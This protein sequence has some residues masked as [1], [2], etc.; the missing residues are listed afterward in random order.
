MF[1]ANIAIGDFFGFDNNYWTL[2]TKAQ[3]IGL[4]DLK[5]I[6]QFILFD[7][8]LESRIK[9]LPAVL[10]AGLTFCANQ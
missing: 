6:L 8:L 9:F 4:F 3:A 1:N 5:I 10:T 2:L 7:R